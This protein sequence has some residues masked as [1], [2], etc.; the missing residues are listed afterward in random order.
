MGIKKCADKLKKMIISVLCVVLI[1]GSMP[2]K[3][4]AGPFQ[5]FIEVILYIPDAVMILVNK[6]IGE[7]SGDT[8]MKV[9][10]KG[11]HITTADE[12]RIYNFTVSPYEIITNGQEVKYTDKNGAE[13]TRL[14][15]PI[16]NADFFHVDS[17]TA[18]TDQTKSNE[19]LRPAIG[20]VYKNLRNF[21][22]ILM[23]LV[24]L[25]I[26][27]KIMIS[28]SAEQ[29]S[30]YKK[31]LVD[32]LVGFCLLFIMHYF[33]VFIMSANNMVTN[34]LAEGE[35]QAYYISFC[36]V[37]WVGGMTPVEGIVSGAAS[38]SGAGIVGSTVGAA[39]RS[40][41]GNW[42]W[43]YIMARIYSKG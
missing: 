40:I 1:F 12:G 30:K 29:Q 27:I 4:K 33:M 2:A 38:G 19:I 3:S 6:Y 16:L 31:N 13:K 26:G 24:L 14:N 34:M 32:W 15:L 41:S 21:C 17:S 36:E 22:M 37:D 9:N 20:N 28:A 35:S 5:D 23:M 42:R 25:Y 10:L 7:I 39:V 43:Q 8:Y 11:L 18:T